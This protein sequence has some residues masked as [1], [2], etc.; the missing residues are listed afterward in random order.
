M[1]DGSFMGGGLVW[2]EKG[3]FIGGFFKIGFSNLSEMKSV[4]IWGLVVC[5]FKV[6]LVV[7]FMIVWGDV[8]GMRICRL[9]V[10]SGLFL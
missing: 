5:G 1:Y 4:F 7:Y 10:V 2:Y 3:I 8:F 9:S 6:K